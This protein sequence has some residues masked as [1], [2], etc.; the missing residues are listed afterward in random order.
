MNQLNGN[1]FAASVGVLLGLGT[2]MGTGAAQA[3]EAP[4]ETVSYGDL[5]LSRST[6]VQT[7]Y[8]RL[9]R[10]SA[11]VC[12]EAPPFIELSRHLVWSRCYHSAL[13]SAVLKISSP[14][15]QALNR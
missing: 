5:D 11:N 15:L 7:L 2:T 14:G 12:G 13:D 8:Y 4:T 1:I 10:A 3:A 6:D 9:E